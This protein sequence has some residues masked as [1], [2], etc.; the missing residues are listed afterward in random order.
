MATPAH[1]APPEP[2]TLWD[3]W[4][5]V[6]ILVVLAYSALL[7]AA[8]GVAS[9]VFTRLGFGM[10]EAGVESPSAR[11]YV[12]LLYG[13]LGAVL[14]GWG[15]LLLA[16][17]EGPLRRR[18]RWAWLAVTA[19]LTCWFLVDTSLSLAVGFPT[20]ALF[21]LAFVAAVTPPLAGLRAACLTG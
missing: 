1:P 14:I 4:L 17:V 5:T 20:H 9:E 2:R 12:L 18:Q 7:V 3:R 13:I 6:A 10:T 8:G 16:V 19:S 15:V 21:N 11:G